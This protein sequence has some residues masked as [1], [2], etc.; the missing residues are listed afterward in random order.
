MEIGVCINR[1]INYMR[2]IVV[3][4]TFVKER[5]RVVLL[6]TI[7]KG[8]N[9]QVITIYWYVYLINIESYLVNNFSI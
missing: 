7:T 1:F 9:N 4:G 5:G 2:P 6:L 3:D 8:E